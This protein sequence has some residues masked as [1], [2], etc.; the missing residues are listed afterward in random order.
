ML[1]LVKI[2][3]MVVFLCFIFHLLLPVGQLKYFFI[4]TVKIIIFIV[5]DKTVIDLYMD[6]LVILSTNLLCLFHSTFS[7]I[8]S[9]G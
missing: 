8:L 7:F 1:T 4:F 9:N 3:V 6:I 2:Y 5:A